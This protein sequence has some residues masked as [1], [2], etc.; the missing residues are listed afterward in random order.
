MFKNNYR[1]AIDSLRSARWRSF[2]T[3]LGI[4]IGVV[5]VVTV[6]SIGEGIK[7]N[8]EAETQQLG[9]NVVSVLP[10]DQIER[11]ESGEIRTFN[12]FAS[13]GF[14]LTQTDLAEINQLDGV[15]ETVA[16][17][18]VP[19]TPTSDDVTMDDA[20]IIATDGN[21][22]DILNQEIRFGSWHE[23]ETGNNRK[24]AVIGHGVA[25][26]LFGE[27]APVGRSFTVNGQTYVIRGVFDEF[28]RSS[29]P[30]MTTDYNRAIFTAFDDNV[31]VS[32]TGQNIY[33]ILVNPSDISQAGELVEEIEAT[34]TESRDGSSDF[35][36]LE[37]SE[38]TA[39]YGGALDML[40]VAIAAIAA[41]S[42]FVGGIGIMNIMFVSVSERTGEIGIRKAIGATNGQILGQFV[43]E[44][45]VMSL[46]GGI[47]GVLF[48]LLVNYFV[49]LFTILE[50][51][52]I[53]ELMVLAVVVAFIV[54]MIFGTAPAIRASRKNP[55]DALR[56]RI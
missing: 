41:I 23:D 8:I 11:D 28:P 20:T 9:A 19:G 35:T 46:L 52:V 6:L 49:R 29:L 22:P 40:T 47:F 27:L 50:P 55:I 3:M 26:D 15:E 43:T 10:G 5:A 14:S 45:A 17:V 32:S 38:L 30:F 42:L 44:A 13:V 56:Y 51:V 24:F 48:S 39:V 16:F 1:M 25:D 33:Q 18:R 37:S 2:L 34:L 31:R 12:P 21:V 54:G 4:I 53:P 36:V 7:R